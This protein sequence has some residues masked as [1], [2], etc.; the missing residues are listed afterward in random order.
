VQELFMLARIR[1]AQGRRPDA[2]ALL[3]RARELEPEVQEIA[4]LLRQAAGP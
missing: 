1:L 3:T 4:D 2:V